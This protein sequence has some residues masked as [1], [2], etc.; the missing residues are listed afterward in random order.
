MS[1]LYLIRHGQAGNRNDYDR[2]SEL[3]HQQSELLGKYLAAQGVEFSAMYCGELRRQRE[4]AANVVEQMQYGGM[5]TPQLQID[6]RWNEFDLGEV[7]SKIGPQVAATS[8]KFR[9]EFREMMDT[10]D[11]PG[12][13][14]H[15]GHTDLDFVVVRAWIE[16]TYPYDGESFADFTGRVQAGLMDL[17]KH[18]GDGPVAVFTSATPTGI[19]VATALELPLNRSL[20]LAG[21]TYNAAYSTMRI[22][23]HGFTLF[24]FNNVPHLD[25][26]GLRTF[27]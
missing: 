5:R 6:P 26:S 2:L 20:R 24:S 27:R 19:A 4:T 25:A 18:S 16:A 9:L 3:G 12:A 13:R 7:Y 11:D 15:R 22:Q 23:E 8:E 17:T 1:A 21:V 14:F 10:W